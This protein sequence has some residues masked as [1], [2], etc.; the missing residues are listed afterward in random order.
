M[1]PSTP[2]VVDEHPAA[3][4]RP[5]GLI[6]KDMATMA[7]GHLDYKHLEFVGPFESVRSKE[8]SEDLGA[9]AVAEQLLS[10]SGENHAAP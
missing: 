8:L 9:P 7:R 1:S 10:S 3:Q 6:N 5:W 4:G 2:V